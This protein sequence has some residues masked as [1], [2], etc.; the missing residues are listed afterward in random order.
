MAKRYERGS[1]T[2]FIPLAPAVGLVAVVAALAAGAVMMGHAEY[3]QR[4]STE[5]IWLR[6]LSGPDIESLGITRAEIIDAV[7]GVVTAHGRGQTVFEPRVHLAPDNGGVG[8]F[9]VLRGHVSTLGEHGISG[10]KVVGDFV[11]NYQRGLPS[12]LALVTLYDPS[13]GVP[14]AIVDATFITEARTGA[15]TA[16]GARA[17]ARPD[18]RVLGHAGARGTAFWNEIGRASCRERVSMFV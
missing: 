15:M 1:W 5:G 16:V 14:L 7:A 18:A 6:F 8:H 9:N 2:P 11:P 3:D 10:I 12:E 13:T 17:L 4:V